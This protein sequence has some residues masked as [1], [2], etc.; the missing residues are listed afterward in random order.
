MSAGDRFNTGAAGPLLPPPPPNRGYANA[1]AASFSHALILMLRRQRVL[2]AAGITML[3]VIIPLALAFLLNSQYSDDGNVNFIRLAEDI[4]INVLAPLLALFFATMLVGEDAESQTLPYTLTRPIPR[5]AWV[6]GRFAAYGVVSCA[7]LC[8]SLFITFA[9][10]TTLEGL[11]FAPDDLRLAAHYAAVACANLFA[12]GALTMFLGAYFKRPIVVGVLLLYGWQYL[13]NL[14][15]GVVDFLTIQK[16]T[17]A[18]LPQLAESRHNVEIR[19]ALL[20]YS[21]E[22]FMVSASKALLTLAGIV[23]GFVAATVITV[24]RREFASAR[25]AGG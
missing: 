21:K 11:S 18:L 19:T 9:A 20:T 4:Y 13:A 7:I 23:V 6:L 24:R 22:I 12:T 2:L 5:S 3:P 10:C 17:D 8:T 25:A 14:V 1:A 16:Y 15:P